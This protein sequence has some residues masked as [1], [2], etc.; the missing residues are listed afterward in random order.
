VLKIIKESHPETSITLFGHPTWQTYTAEYSSDFFR[1]NA[2]FYTV[3][4]ANPTS[5][6]V[7]SFISKYHRWYS[8]DLINLFPKYG[9]LG[10]DTGMFF[11]QLL[12]Q[13]GTTSDV[14]VNNLKYNGIQTDFHF[15]RINNWGGFIN[16]N[17]YFVEFGKDLKIHIKRIE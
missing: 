8:R 16:V 17:I 9:M 7:K 4:Y 11:I 3:F 1:L 14:N 13:Y 10:Y 2:H 15:D 12:N 5:A 6:E